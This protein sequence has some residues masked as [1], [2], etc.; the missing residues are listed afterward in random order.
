MQNNSLDA[1]SESD[2]IRSIRNPLTP[3]GGPTSEDQR[4]ARPTP[5]TTDNSSSPTPPGSVAS[6]PPDP[7]SPGP[8]TAAAGS[9][10][11]RASLS[12]NPG[13]FRAVLKSAATQGNATT[14][15]K[16]DGTP[17]EG[18]SATGEAAGGGVAPS[19]QVL[20]PP[21]PSRQASQSS[22]RA[23]PEPTRRG[24]RSS[25]SSKFLR[26]PSTKSTHAEAGDAAA[27]GRARPAAESGNEPASGL[28]RDDP[29]SQ[30]PPRKPLRRRVSMSF[31]PS[32]LKKAVG[33]SSGQDNQRSSATKTSEDS[34]QQPLEYEP[35]PVALGTAAPPFRVH[36][37]P[38]AVRA[39]MRAA[40][41]LSPTAV[42]AAMRSAMARDS[43]G[44]SNS[45]GIPKDSE[46]EVT[47][48]GGRSQRRDQSD[49]P[50]VFSSMTT[51]AAAPEPTAPPPLAYQQ[52]AQQRRRRSL[53]RSASFTAGTRRSA[54]A[55]S[56]WRGQDKVG[57][58]TRDVEI[59]PKDQDSGNDNS[60]ECSRDLLGSGGSGG[61]GGSFGSGRR[62]S[63]SS[64]RRRRLRGRSMSLSLVGR[65]ASSA[66]IGL[67]NPSSPTSYVPSSYVRGD[68]PGN[69]S[70]SSSRSPALANGGDAGSA[71]GGFRQRLRQRAAGVGVGGTVGGGFHRRSKTR[72]ASPPHSNGPLLG[73][74]ARTMSASSDLLSLDSSGSWAG[75]GWR[76]FG[77]FDDGERHRG[78][79]LPSILDAVPV[80]KRPGLL[81]GLQERCV[82]TAVG[83]GERIASLP[84]C[85]HVG[86]R[87]GTLVLLHGNTILFTGLRALVSTP[88]LALLC[89]SSETRNHQACT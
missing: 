25:I 37:H 64:G 23:G 59:A 74:H 75:P 70:G 17:E 9:R 42:R 45:G 53:R 24:V 12:L 76:G 36:P 34:L 67:S 56:E 86:N 69:R 72:S 10:R 55:M 88:M 79:G 87:V 14:R 57:S 27:A 77:G 20:P 63:S 84:D 2:T 71:N 31:S 89:S 33:L 73:G 18:P 58:H 47:T 16:Q 68:G 82:P 78:G 13:A 60:D 29:A 8:A 4:R 41:S 48:N 32:S 3:P 85:L 52:Q 46:L 6:L 22:A 38:P 11:R 44:R 39:A 51:V 81:Q 30:A 19:R 1:V 28:E 54:M 26:S 61:S 66:A 49:Q 7:A 50:V 15:R 80:W 35:P 65:A 5:A 83:S 43:S 40:N 62:P 21:A